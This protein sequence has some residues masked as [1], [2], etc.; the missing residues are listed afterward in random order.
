MCDYCSFIVKV[1]LLFVCSGGKAMF[2]RSGGAE[3]R[4]GD[5]DTVRFE[6]RSR[7]GASGGV[8]IDVSA[9]SSPIYSPIYNIISIDCT[10]LLL[11][12]VVK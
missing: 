5:S 8:Y 7:L 2:S 12:N 11:Q 6:S 4:P 10:L 1:R 3:F 9:D